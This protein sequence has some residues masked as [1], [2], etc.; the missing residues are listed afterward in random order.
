M[1]NFRRESFEKFGAIKH[2]RF[3]HLVQERRLKRY[4]RRLSRRDLRRDLA[5]ES[6]EGVT[7]ETR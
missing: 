4:A 3:H 6:G 2:M 7:N 1:D 5:L